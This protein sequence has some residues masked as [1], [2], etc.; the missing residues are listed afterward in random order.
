MPP[1]VITKDMIDKAFEVIRDSVKE[2][3]KRA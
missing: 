3:E 1:L 2:L